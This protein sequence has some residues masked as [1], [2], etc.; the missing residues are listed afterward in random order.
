M[1]PKAEYIRR[2]HSRKLYRPVFM[3]RLDKP[4]TK[5][6]SFVRLSMAREALVEER[7]IH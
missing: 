2:D 7:L 3:P 4:L 1:N 6:D 5:V